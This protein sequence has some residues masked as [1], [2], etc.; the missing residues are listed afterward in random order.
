MS[1]RRQRHLHVRFLENRRKA[2]D[3]E[4]QQERNRAGAHQ[5]QQARVDHG[6][7]DVVPQVVAR[8]LEFRET[9]E[10]GASEPDASPARTMLTYR[11]EK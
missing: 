1:M 10:D 5:R 7:D 9:V 2:R 3:H 4:G 6:R 8:A 11:S